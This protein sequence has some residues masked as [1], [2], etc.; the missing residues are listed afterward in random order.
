MIILIFGKDG[1]VGKALQTLFQEVSNLNSHTCKPVF[2]GRN[3][4]D[5]S[6][7]QDLQGV[8]N[9]HQPDIIINASAYT[10]VDKAEVEPDLVFTINAKA[11]ELM[12]KHIA[13]K[14]NGLLI[15]FSTD[16]VFGDSQIEPYREDD[17]TGP[18][19]RLGVYG[20]SKLAGEK[21]ITKVFEKEI[22]HS[23]YYIL[24]TSWVYGEGD[25]FIKTILRLA[26]EKDS[27]KIVVDQV[28]VPT[29]AKFLAQVTIKL[30]SSHV[31]SPNKSCSGIYHVVP[32]GTSSWYS[33]AKFSIDFLRQLGGV[34]KVE[35]IKPISSKEYPLPA[36]RPCNS[37]LD[38]EK[39]KIY[40]SCLQI[41]LEFASWHEQVKV[42]IRDLYL[43]KKV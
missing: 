32:D 28:G 29:S 42:Y 15:H 14:D 18:E 31:T 39:L 26:K 7:L 24:R 35:N 25:N 4:C 9:H 38:N 16:Y 2:L 8:I 3:D 27:L 5:L 22:N 12:A 6:N 10:A 21:L 20:R 30:L 41:K 33:L 34:L 40:L 11:C 17:Q 23:T 19:N 37:R 36:P 43:D 13:K 1:Q